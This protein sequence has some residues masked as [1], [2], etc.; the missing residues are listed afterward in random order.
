VPKDD[1]QLPP[2]SLDT[3][4]LVDTYHYIENRAEYARRLRAALA[5]G[6]RVVIIDYVPKSWKK[7]PW[8]PLPG[9]QVSRETVDKE[10]A[11]A[12]LKPVR[13]HSFLPEQYFVE[14]AVRN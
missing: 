5:P 3:I 11:A 6:G 13:S 14:Y 4:L 2:A 9:Q 7:R 8:G 12:G 10:M 1:P